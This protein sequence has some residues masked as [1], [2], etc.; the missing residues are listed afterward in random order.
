MAVHGGFR[1]RAQVNEMPLLV[2]CDL[3]PRI[4]VISRQVNASPAP[5][6]SVVSH[7]IFL[8]SFPDVRNIIPRSTTILYGY[9]FLKCSMLSVG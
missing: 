5:V 7:V 2:D 4:L 1:Y 6:V 8:T 9:P 3:C